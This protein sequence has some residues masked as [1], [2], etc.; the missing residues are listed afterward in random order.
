MQRRTEVASGLNILI[1]VLLG[2]VSCV[3]VCTSDR[4]VEL[5]SG[6]VLCGLFGFQ[7]QWYYL[8]SIIHALEY[9]HKQQ[10]LIGFCFF[11]YFGSCILPYIFDDYD[12]FFIKKSVEFRIYL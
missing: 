11:K 1:K 3:V 5:V 12:H 7:S 10:Y 8:L 6:G 4:L 9:L 2:L